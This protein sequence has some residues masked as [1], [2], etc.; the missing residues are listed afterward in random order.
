MTEKRK[1]GRPAYEPS[2]RDRSQVKMLCAMGVPDYDIA[3]VM[4]L[5][6]P[7]LR[8]HFFRELEVGHIESTAKVAQSLFKQATDPVK[9]N[10][11]AAI[12][13]MKCRG[14]W[15]EESAD[16]PGKKEQRQ[17]AA[18]EAGQGTSWG[19]DLKPNASALN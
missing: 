11:A 19:D 12:F 9:P 14:G 18:H 13:W 8:K 2:E 10:V 7:T 17:A 1:P 4:H 6:A 16:A 15:R 5:S 3:L